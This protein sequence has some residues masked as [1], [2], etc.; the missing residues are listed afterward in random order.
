MAVEVCDQPYNAISVMRLGVVDYRSVWTLQKELQRKRIAGACGDT[1]IVC[2]HNPVITLGRRANSD[3]I[4][5]DRTSLATRGIDVVE[6]ERGG[7]VTWHGPGQLIC[8]PILDLS[9][10]RKDVGWYMRSLEEVVLRTLHSFSVEAGR[11]PGRTGVWVF[12]E[13]DHV[14]ARSSKIASIGVRISRWCTLHGLSLN[15]YDCSHG[16]STIHPCGFQDIG[17]TSMEEE[18]A[19]GHTALDHH[20]ARPTNTTDA[21]RSARAQVQRRVPDIERVATDLVAKFKEVFDYDSELHY[22]SN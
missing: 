14:Q 9:L 20:I 19:R 6:V 18:L 3:N 21:I 7:D 11:F 5:V 8:Y 1:L 2:Q 22:A 17:V 10:K 16:F 13:T 12:H 15:V 4:L